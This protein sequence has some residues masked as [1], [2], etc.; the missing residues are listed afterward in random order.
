MT[1]FASASGTANA[2][3]VVFA[4]I[5]QIVVEYVGDQR[6]MQTARGDIGGNQNIEV[7]LSEIVENAQTFFLHYAVHVVFA[8]IRQIVVEYVG[9]QRDMQTARGDIGGNQNIEVAL[10]EI[11]ENAQTFFLHYVASKQANAV[12]IGS[13]VT[14]DVFTEVFGIGKNDGAIRPLFLY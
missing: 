7:A 6:D 4:I 13:Q 9:D 12:T 3:H 5:R 10:S 14:P 2:V 1:A 8:I 11:V